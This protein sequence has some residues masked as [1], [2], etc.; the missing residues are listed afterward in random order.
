MHQP[1]RIVGLASDVV[2]KALAL[3]VVGGLLF[4]VVRVLRGLVGVGRIDTTV[5]ALRPLFDFRLFSTGF[6]F[7]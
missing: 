6:F 2:K 3:V 5:L 7:A 1:S 4:T